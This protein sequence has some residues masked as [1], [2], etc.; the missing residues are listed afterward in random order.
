MTLATRIIFRNPVNPEEV[1]ALCDAL[2]NDRGVPSSVDRTPGEI[3]NTIGQGN[4]S[5][6]DVNFDAEGGTLDETPGYLADCARYEAEYGPEEAANPD[7][8]QRHCPPGPYFVK[9]RLDTSYGFSEPGIGG[10]ADFHAGIIR[11]LLAEFPEGGIVWYNEYAGTWHEGDEGFDGLVT[12]GMAG[13][14]WFLNVVSP[15]IQAEAA[16]SGAEITWS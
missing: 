14:D 15:V 1:Y 8:M 6:L 16:V 11:A 13:T 7:P 9:V 4:R 2:V 12:D 10:C 5:M 3:S